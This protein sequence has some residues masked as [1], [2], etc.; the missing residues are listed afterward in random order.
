MINR[1]I[2]VGMID[3]YYE[4]LNYYFIARKKEMVAHIRC[5]IRLHSLAKTPLSS[6]R[7]SLQRHTY[8]HAHAHPF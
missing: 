2:T 3:D 7:H 1:T 4:R 5:S 8:T 6:R